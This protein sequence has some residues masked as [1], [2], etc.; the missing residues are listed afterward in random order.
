MREITG[1]GGA[2][3]GAPEKSRWLFHL[4]G[5]TLCARF[6]VAA[7]RLIP[8]PPQA[9]IGRTCDLSPRPRPATSVRAGCPDEST[10]SFHVARIARPAG[11]PSA[12]P[13]L[14][15]SQPSDADPKR[16]RPP[17][18]P[19]VTIC[20]RVPRT[21]PARGVRRHVPGRRVTPSRARRGPWWGQRSWPRPRISGLRAEL[22]VYLEP[23]DVTVASVQS[24]DLVPNGWG[25]R[26]S[27]HLCIDRSTVLTPS[28]MHIDGYC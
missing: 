20:A 8:R 13:G 17:R 7:S 9:P 14:A 5:A 11:R 15:R 26:L 22:G 25:R 16:H 10:R 4:V 24:V 28:S 27:N 23:P 12:R 18:S 3:L 21:A 6:L 1:C 19:T 2:R